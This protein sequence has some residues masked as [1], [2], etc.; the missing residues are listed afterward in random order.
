MLL[1]A[2]ASNQLAARLAGVHSYGR[3][4]TVSN[5]ASM[6]E[7]LRNVQPR[8]ILLDMELPGLQR[9]RRLADLAAPCR[10][11]KLIALHRAPVDELELDCFRYAGAKACCSADLPPEDLMRVIA[12]VERGELWISRRLMARLTQELIDHRIM[13]TF[14]PAN[15]GPIELTPRER[16]IALQVSAGNSNKQIARQL[17]ITERTVKAHL[18][19]VFRKMGVNDRLT[20]ALRI[21]TP[22]ERAPSEIARSA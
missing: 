11:S 3:W 4:L 15:H 5:H 2:S 10:H 1:L 6:L 7:V 18:S 9:G 17:D 13:Q 14:T 20:L 22:I 12:A 19:E 21:A 8:L 16:E